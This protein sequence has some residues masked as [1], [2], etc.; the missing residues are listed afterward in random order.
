MPAPLAR[1]ALPFQK[2]VP[3]FGSFETLLGIIP[4]RVSK[5]TN[6]FIEGLDSALCECDEEVGRFSAMAA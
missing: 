3:A 5:E 1:H 2:I 4:L 6:E